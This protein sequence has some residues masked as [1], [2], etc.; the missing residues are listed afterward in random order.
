MSSNSKLTRNKLTILPRTSSKVHVYYSPIQ[1]LGEMY[2]FSI[3]EPYNLKLDYIWW[4][5]DNW[6]YCTKCLLEFKDLD[7]HWY[8]CAHSDSV[9]LT[10][11]FDIKRDTPKFKACV[12]CK[13][14][15]KNMRNHFQIPNVSMTSANI[16]R[17]LLKTSCCPIF[18]LLKELN[19][20]PECILSRLPFEIIEKIFILWT[21]NNI[22]SEKLFIFNV[23]M[24]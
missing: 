7:T 13:C 3:G 10:R 22:C 18:E 9:Y 2:T 11:E 17:Q 12:F 14:F 6:Y 21:T 23:S 8:S 20:T 4:K 15:G 5:S 24:A 19:N 16:R 1:Y